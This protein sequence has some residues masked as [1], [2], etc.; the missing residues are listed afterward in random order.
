MAWFDCRGSVR[1]LREEVRI[2]GPGRWRIRT[3]CHQGQHYESLW[4][5]DDARA[6]DDCVPVS[7]CKG[8]SKSEKFRLIP[9]DELTWREQTV[10]DIAVVIPQGVVVVSERVRRASGRPFFKVY[11]GG[12]RIPPKLLARD[13]AH[14]LNEG[15]SVVVRSM[16]REKDARINTYRVVNSFGY[17][18]KQLLSRI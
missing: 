4:P 14:I 5:L 12:Q 13:G 8:H 1:L 3:Y 17:G 6:T 16:D 10:M 9:Y 7:A 15:E 2:L 11:C 18:Q